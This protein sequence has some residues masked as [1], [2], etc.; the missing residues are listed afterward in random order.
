MDLLWRMALRIAYRFALLY[1]LIVRPSKR[2]VYVAVW[3]GQ[4]ILLI[5]NSYKPRETFPAGGI[6]RGEQPIHAAARELGEEVGIYIYPEELSAAKEFLSRQEF[7]ND[8]SMV[9]ELQFTSEP[10]L[11]V[12]RREVTAAEFVDANEARL[13]SLTSIVEQYLD[14]KLAD[15]RDSST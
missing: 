14:W 11:T 10:T 7:K 3:Y 6:K 15:T 8:S 9:F 2:G 1:W 13:R 4:R 12:D 5:K